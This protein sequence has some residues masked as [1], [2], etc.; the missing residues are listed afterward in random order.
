MEARFFEG[1]A[2]FHTLGRWFRSLSYHPSSSSH[3]PVSATL[4]ALKSLLGLAMVVEARDPYTAGHLWRVSQLARLLAERAGLSPQ[5][6]AY[7]EAGGF[8]HDLGKVAMPDH[9][10]FKGGPLTPD[11]FEIMKTHPTVGA[12]MLSP[13]ALGSAVHAAVLSHHERPDGEGYPQGLSGESVPMVARVVGLADA[14]D[15]MTSDRPYRKGM[16][17]GRATEIIRAERGKQFDARWVDVLTDKVR[18]HELAHIVGHSDEGLPLA[19]CPVCQGP[20][21]MPRGAG[22]GMTACRICGAEL[23]VVKT[24]GVLDLR[25]TGRKASAEQ[26]QPQP[27]LALIEVMARGMAPYAAC[28]T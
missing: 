5:E 17:M 21:A 20:L 3:A 7:C 6:R 8:L 23:E 14:F 4:G 11:E 24:H 1:D 25:P 9:V 12:H 10:L 18:I 27:D 28:R 16:P 26:L 13:H 22:P 2:M 15:A 19:S